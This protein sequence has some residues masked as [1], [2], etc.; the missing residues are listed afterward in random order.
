[1]SQIDVPQQES[2]ITRYPKLIS[3]NCTQKIIEQMQKNICKIKIGQEQGTGFFCEIPFPDKN[4]MLKVFI[5]NN[6]V[7]D[8]K[9]LY[10]DDAK[11]SI[12]IKEERDSRTIYLKNRM[13]YTNKEYDITIFEI[14]DNE[15]IKNY[16]Q[17][18]DNI[19]NDIINEDNRNGDYIDQTLYIIQYPEG[20]LSVSYGILDNIYFDQKFNFN[21]KCST[22]GGA[23]GSPILTLNNKVIGIHKEGVG[24]KYNHGS[25]LNYPIKDF[26]KLNYNA[27]KN[28][29]SLIDNK[30]K[31]INQINNN[32]INNNS[33]NINNNSN[34]IINNNI[35]INNINNNNNII[36]NNIN[37]LSL[38]EF[39]KNHG[40]DIKDTNITELNLIQ[41][42]L[43][44]E[45]L[46]DLSKI[47]FK[48][49]KDLNLK[50]NTIS[51]I[52]ALQHVKFNKLEILNLSSNMISDINVLEK[53]NFKELKQLILDHNNISDINVLGKVNFNKLEVLDLN[54][55]KISD[56]NVLEKVN[57]KG[58]RTL[59]LNANKI[60]DMTVFKKTKFNKL[61]MLHLFKNEIDKTKDENIISK[62]K[63]KIKDFSI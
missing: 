49:L 41:S 17:L 37:N 14:K 33:N 7:I 55:N 6:H 1:M 5:T 50:T 3:Y 26:I 27:N 31:Y 19:I 46:D 8:E 12:K 59:N 13:K 11:I 38:E 61:E 57:F 28:N 51:D 44:D 15:E 48:E 32:N 16:L 60:T 30:D 40:L 2:L 35:N 62:L 53:V 34:N 43:D 9:L 22:K 54:T 29:Q 23:S 4:N 63:A 58:L 24:N 39:N 36:I 20:E 10:N 18:D 45:I 21:H 56:I 42:M 25:F 47:E 52:K